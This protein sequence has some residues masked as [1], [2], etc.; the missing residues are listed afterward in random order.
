MLLGIGMACN[1]MG[2]FAL[3]A[4]WFPA[5]RFATLAGVLTAAGTAGM[6][7]A[8]TPLAWLAETVGWRETFTLVAVLNLAQ[9][10]MLFVFVRDAPDKKVRASEGGREEMMK[11]IVYLWTRPWFW[12]VNLATF[13]RFGAFMALQGLL[14][15]PYLIYGHDLSPVQTGNVLLACSLGYVAGLPLA[16]RLSDKTLNTRKYV[17]APAL[18]LSAALFSGL[19]LLS[20]GAPMAVYAGL[21]LVI[22]FFSAPGNIVYAHI[23]ELCPLEMSGTAMSGVNLFNMLGPAVLIQVGGAFMP[24]NPAGVSG[25]EAFRPVWLIF[26]AGLAV[27][28]LFYFAVPDTRRNASRT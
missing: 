1:L 24:E 17:V 16:G 22:G 6:I 4:A 23:K 18:L 20:G 26:A 2:A 14:A 3:V 21:F 5:E 27:S 28:G 12:V 19:T 10:A 7:F 8:A 9:V 11:R 13:F 25:P 15:G